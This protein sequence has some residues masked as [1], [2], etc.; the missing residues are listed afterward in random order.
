MD[1]ESSNDAFFSCLVSGRGGEERPGNGGDRDVEQDRLQPEDCGKRAADF[2]I[3]GGNEADVG[4]Y[5]WQVRIFLKNN[6]RI[7]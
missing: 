5:P 6:I 3:I 4:E 1:I 2:K 7:Y